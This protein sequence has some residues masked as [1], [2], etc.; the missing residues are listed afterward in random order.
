MQA[1]IGID[2]GQKGGISFLKGENYEAYRMPKTLGETVCLFMMMRSMADG[3]VLVGIEKVH[4]MPGQGVVGVFNFG[5]GYGALLGILECIGW[6]YEEVTPRTWQKNVLGPE[7]GNTKERSLTWARENY[8]EVDLRY[9]VD[10]GKSDSLA[11]ATYMRNKY[12]N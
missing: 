12:D 3:P 5:K 8:P 6:D 7:T 9:K 11:L 4:S 10:D 1:F 2:V